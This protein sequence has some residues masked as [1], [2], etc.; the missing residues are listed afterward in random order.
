MDISVTIGNILE[1][2][3]DAIVLNLFEGVDEPGGA[4]GAADKA[5]NGAVRNLIA[6][7]DF[8]GKFQQ[9]SILYPQDG[10][11]AKRLILVGLGKQKEFVF[12]TPHIFL[13]VL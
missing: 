6:G 12:F 10:I 11:A 1:Q 3:P 4:T 8:T 9:T 13:D 2:Q 7:G 5:L